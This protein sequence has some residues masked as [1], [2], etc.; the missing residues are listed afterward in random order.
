MKSRVNE[1]GQFAPEIGWSC[2][3]VKGWSVYPFYALWGNDR[4]IK[5]NYKIFLNMIYLAR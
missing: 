2:S 1:G 4:V 3:S 5:L